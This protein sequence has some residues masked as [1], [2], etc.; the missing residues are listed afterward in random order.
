MKANPSRRLAATGA[1]A[2]STHWAGP[3]PLAVS[4][5]ESWYG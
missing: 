5:D 4:V 2:S 3:M 1:Q